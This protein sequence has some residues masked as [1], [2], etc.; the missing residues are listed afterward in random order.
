MHFAPESRNTIH[1]IAL[2]SVSDDAFARNRLEVRVEPLPN[3]H[4]PIQCNI[5][6]QSFPLVEFPALVDSHLSA[7][8]AKCTIFGLEMLIAL[9]SGVPEKLG[10]FGDYQNLM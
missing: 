7:Y 1:R 10:P 2:G 5:T 4:P 6:S 8:R 3:H 9:A